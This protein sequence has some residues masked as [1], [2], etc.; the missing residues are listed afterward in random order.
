VPCSNQQGPRKV[1]PWWALGL[2]VW[3]PTKS[4][5]NGFRIAIPTTR[6]QAVFSKIIQKID[7]FEGQVIDKSWNL[8]FRDYYP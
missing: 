5:G 4:I 6:F 8:A 1:S 3:H 2:F 7:C